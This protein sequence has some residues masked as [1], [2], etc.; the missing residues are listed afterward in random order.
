MSAQRC[1]ARPYARI[2]WIASYRGTI[3]DPT[4][5]RR[6]RAAAL[7]PSSPHPGPA[8]EVDD[9]GHD[10][11]RPAARERRGRRAAHPRA[12]GRPRR[13]RGAAA[14]A[15]SRSPPGSRSSPPTCARS[16]APR[17]GCWP[18]AARSPCC[19]CS[20]LALVAL[21]RAQEPAL[22]A[23]RPRE[24]AARP[25]RAR[26]SPPA[27]RGTRS[28]TVPYLA[29]VAPAVLD[30]ATDGALLAGYIGSYLVFVDRL[31]VL[32][33]RHDPGAGV[34]SR[35]AVDRA[36]GGRGAGDRA[37]ADGDPDAGAGGGGRAA[38]YS[39]AMSHQ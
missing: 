37:R 9:D 33:R 39:A 23:L 13:R 31:G 22:V 35:G 29:D 21:H 38:G 25:R 19:C 2:G 14:S 36:A 32:R 18:R 12:L 30:R 3:P 17:A 34:L 1:T 4:V 28:F 11:R 5:A 26:C 6:R 27:G 24:R 20:A 15:C 10:D 8:E 7:R 16:P